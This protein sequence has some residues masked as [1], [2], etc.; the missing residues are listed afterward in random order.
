MAP[1]EI[2]TK[3]SVTITVD[4]TCY[5]R[6][7]NPV[8]S[9]INVENASFSTKLLAA[10]TLRNVLGIKT[11]QEILQEKETIA[12]YMQVKNKTNR[13]LDYMIV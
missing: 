4:A 7:V 8:S 12:H 2:L 9:V 5:F 13:R 11:L 10:T 1:Q 6:V 3:D